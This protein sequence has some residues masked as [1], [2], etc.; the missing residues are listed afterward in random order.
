ME[1]QKSPRRA[2]L[3]V[4]DDSDAQANLKDILEL[5]D[6]DVQCLCL[7]ADVYEQDNL[8]E[9]LTILLDLNLPDGHADGLL[10]YLREEA[11]DV[12]VILMTG[13]GDWEGTMLGLRHGAAEFL[14]KPIEPDVLRSHVNRIREQQRI[15][16]EL[17]ETQRK[18]V[19]FERLAAIGQTITTLS[20]EARN[21]LNGLK[22]GLSL[23]PQVLDDRKTAIEIIGY[24]M[25]SEGR[26]QHLLD[27]VRGFAGP[28]QLE[29]AVCDLRSV[30]RSA[31]TSLESVWCNRDASFEEEVGQVDLTLSVDA[32]RLEQVFRNLFE[33]SLAAC[34]D[35]A[36]IR[37]SCSP[38]FGKNPSLSIRVADN[39]PGLSG[40][41]KEK[42]FDAFYTTKASG[43]GLGMSIVKRIIEAHGGTICVSED[44]LQ[45]AE[46]RITLPQP[47]SRPAEDIRR[48][49]RTCS[50]AMAPENSPPF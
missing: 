50:P 19:R 32:F 21:E 47:L 1:N 42:V 40:E 20:H 41:Q 7:A 23:L 48:R 16:E 14:K 34:G 18:L 2:V 43:T 5:D 28:I 22:M 46:F 35:P 45:G 25:Q 3:V 38:A 10:P 33:N 49:D 27:D 8:A 6:Y 36:V 26:L 12:P 24:M 39:G 9:F 11:P 17:Q 31:W 30:W 29:P 44:T 4:E 13:F 15:R 37:L